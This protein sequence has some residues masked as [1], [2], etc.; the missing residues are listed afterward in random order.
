MKSNFSIRLAAVSD[1][2]PR[3]IPSTVTMVPLPPGEHVD[4]V[5]NIYAYTAVIMQQ[6]YAIVIDG[7]VHLL[8]AHRSASDVG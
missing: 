6:S 7:V 1:L 4:F 2:P 8:P 5:L 3:P